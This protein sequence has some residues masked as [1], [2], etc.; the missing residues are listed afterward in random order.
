MSSI[1]AAWWL[2]VPTD[3]ADILNVTA[4]SN[5][6]WSATQQDASSFTNLSGWTNTVYTWASGDAW[7]SNVPDGVQQ[8]QTFTG[9]SY[10]SSLY[11]P[12]QKAFLVDV[13]GYWNNPISA[14]AA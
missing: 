10:T 6:A 12:Q 8:G 2:I 9:L 1:N 14:T 11:D 4:L 7:P 13:A 5:P 3:S